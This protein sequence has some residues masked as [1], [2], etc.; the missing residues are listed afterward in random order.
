MHT[1]I[2][3]TCLL[4]KGE[5]NRVRSDEKRDLFIL[6]KEREEREGGG[7]KGRKAGGGSEAPFGID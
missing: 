4:L 7:S 2:Y 5:I 1:Y 3:V 6:E